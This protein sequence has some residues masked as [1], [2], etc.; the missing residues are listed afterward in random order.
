[1]PSSRVWPLHCHEQWLSHMTSRRTRVALA[2]TW[3]LG[4]ASVSVN[5]GQGRG[6]RS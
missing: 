5:S 4:P 1:R 3:P 2:S 6:W